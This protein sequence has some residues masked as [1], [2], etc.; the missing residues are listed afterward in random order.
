MSK[1]YPI[2]YLNVNL[3]RMRSFGIG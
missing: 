1:N 2:I 3:L